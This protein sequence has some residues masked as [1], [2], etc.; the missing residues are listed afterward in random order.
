MSVMF[1]SC[2]EDNGTINGC[3]CS[4]AYPGEATQVE[5]LSYTEMKGQYG[6]TSCSA[7]KGVLDNIVSDS[8]VKISCNKY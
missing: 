2:K 6:V 1:V 3:T 5:S 7:L 4:Y 8:N